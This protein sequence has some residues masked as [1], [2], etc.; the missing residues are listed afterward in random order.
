[1]ITLEEVYSE[2]NE[3]D[4]YEGVTHYCKNCMYKFTMPTQ[5]LDDTIIWLNNET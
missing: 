1:L 5:M 3:G 4:F 2:V